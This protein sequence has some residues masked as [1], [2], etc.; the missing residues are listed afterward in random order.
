MIRKATSIATLLV[1]STVLSLSSNA[2]DHE[3][4][5]FLNPHLG[6]YNFDS[7]RRLDD[8]IFPGLGI[9]YQF[10][11][12]WALEFNY[13][14]N[15]TDAKSPGNNEVD[16]D[17][18]RL[19]ALYHF[20]PRDKWQPY[21]AFGIGENNFDSSFGDSDETLF[22]LGGGIKYF[23]TE[24][25]SLRTDLRLFNSMDEEDQDLAL[26][27][28]LNYSFGAPARKATPRAS[29]STQTVTAP[30]DMDKDGVVDAIDQC[31]NTPT[32]VRVTAVGCPIDS[33]NDGV[34]DFRDNCPDSESGSRVDEKG[35][36]IVLQETK[37][38]ELRIN[39]ANNS[40]VV[41]E[42]TIVRIQEVAEFMTQYPLTKVVVEGHTDDRGQANYNQQ[43]SER[44][45]KAVAAILVDRL[46]IA[47]SRVSAI[48]KGE[49]EPL[50]SNDTAEGRA[51]NRRV[52][53]VISAT[54]ETRA[55]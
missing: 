25:L 49:A 1:S 12:A 8:T 3:V 5:F 22:N 11:N 17:Q 50:V 40:D 6:F 16:F 48:G 39:F 52:V 4:G 36:Y 15:E 55:Q 23:L 27:V 45:A 33:D 54:V 51:T 53:G 44:R 24:A 47:Q 9:G 35:C 30:M 46:G 31:P 7:D 14:A 10:D 34:A 38:I 13:L 41:P 42:Q 26:S 37:E 21:A 20:A 29:T 32:N 2:D 19:D 43:L 18:Y 28:G